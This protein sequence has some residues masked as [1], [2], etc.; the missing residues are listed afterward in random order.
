[1]CLLGFSS[2]GRF[3]LVDIYICLFASTTQPRTQ[4]LN[5]QEHRLKIDLNED[6]NPP[7]ASCI[8]ADLHSILMYFYLL[9]LVVVIS[10]DPEV[11]NRSRCLRI[12]AIT[13]NVHCKWTYKHI[14]TL[15]HLRTSNFIS[16]INQWT[17]GGM[18]VQGF[19]KAHAENSKTEKLWD[20]ASSSTSSVYK[21]LTT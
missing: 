16:G 20:V 14:S 21:G 10:L 4:R 2:G 1:M 3:L 9:N 8:H 6:Q 13:Y 15:Q 7:L 19:T 5:R 12:A 17:E 18:Q 11:P